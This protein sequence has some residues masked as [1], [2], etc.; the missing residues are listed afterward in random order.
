ML[1]VS[2]GLFTLGT[3]MGNTP[4]WPRIALK[5]GLLLSFPL[6]LYPLNFYEKIEI[7]RIVQFFRREKTWQNDRRKS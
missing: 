3:S 2:L 7:E 5:T 4:L 6:I 1:A